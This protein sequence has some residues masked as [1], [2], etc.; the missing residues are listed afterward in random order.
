MTTPS[1]DAQA[2]LRAGPHIFDARVLDRIERRSKWAGLVVLF[3][4]AIVL[5][6]FGASIAKLRSLRA[7]SDRAQ[8][9]F[10][11]TSKQLDAKQA[12]L[13]AATKQL[14]QVNSQ[15]KFRQ[16]VYAQ[17]LA[18]NQIPAAALS[19]AADSAIQSDP[20]FAQQIEPSVSIQISREDQRP[21]A[22][23]IQSK[24]QA[25][26]YQVPLIEYVGKRAPDESQL[27]Y[28]F[29]SDAGP[30]LTQIE[31]VLQ[32]SGINAISQFIGLQHAPPTLRPKVFEI[33]LGL[34]YTPP[35]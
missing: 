32:Q 29:K 8:L 27:R 17:L 35:K 11:A 9:Q 30:S 33:W 34:N 12:A 22:L 6:S 16:N 25:L 21:K 4:A 15:L 20:N 26:K 2:E 1:P 24:L 31:Q 23:E 14:D 7:A 10:E 19:T 3:G 28:F 13:A 5:V 18:K